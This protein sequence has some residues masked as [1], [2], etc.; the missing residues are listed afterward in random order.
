MISL[1]LWKILFIYLLM[2]PTSAM[3]S[4]ILQTGKQQP[5]PSLQTLKKITSWSKT[6]NVSF[7]PDK[8]RD[9]DIS[10]QK[11]HLANPPIYFLNSPLE[12]VQSF[13]LP[14]LTISY[15]LFSANH[16]SKLASNVSR[17]L[18]ILR[19]TNYCLGTPELLFTS[20]AFIRRLMEY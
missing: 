14:G 7:N 4:L 5:L 19:H 11:N 13:K 8:S 18:G 15:D 9:H 2:T 3:T 6:W 16:I 1:T 12:E 17:R 20:K 10:F